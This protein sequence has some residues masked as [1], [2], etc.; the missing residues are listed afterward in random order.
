MKKLLDW[1]HLSI[2]CVVFGIS[3]Q[4]WI[5]WVL[6]CHL[7]SE[8]RKREGLFPWWVLHAVY[9]FTYVLHLAPFFFWNEIR[10]HES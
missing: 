10:V 3:S 7:H 2:L 1:T 8:E 4:S 6:V 9:L 5:S